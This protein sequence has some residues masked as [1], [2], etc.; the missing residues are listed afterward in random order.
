MRETIRKYHLLYVIE[1][2][3]K[4]LVCANIGELSDNG[5]RYR[6]FCSLHKPQFIRQWS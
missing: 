6:M 2:Q 4:L 5:E 1:W 3:I